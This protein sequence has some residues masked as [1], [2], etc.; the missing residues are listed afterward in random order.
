VLLDQPYVKA[1]L[2]YTGRKGNCLPLD[3][4]FTDFS[5]EFVS[6]CGYVV[7]TVNREEVLEGF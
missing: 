7:Y 5:G 6:K 1:A 2:L 4:N 3:C